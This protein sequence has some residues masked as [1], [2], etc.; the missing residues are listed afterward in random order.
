MSLEK[1]PAYWTC[2]GSQADV[3]GHLY[4]FAPVDRSPTPIAEQHE[5]RALVDICGDGSL[6]G[7]ELVY[8]MPP[9]PEPQQPVE[10][11]WGD[12]I[13][14]VPMVPGWDWRRYAKHGPF[15]LCRD[16]KPLEAKAQFANYRF[17]VSTAQQG[18]DGELHQLAAAIQAHSERNG[19]EE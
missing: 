18:I 5:V 2:D 12:P 14:T 11:D 8:D 19:Q 16:G 7:V 6:G 17:R 9:P 4:Y 1:R 13:E 10:P 3:V 15:F